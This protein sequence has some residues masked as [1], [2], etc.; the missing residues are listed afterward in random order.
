MAKNE[1]IDNKDKDQG[2]EK[3]VKTLKKS[4]Y[5]KKKKIKKKYIKRYCLCSIYI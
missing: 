2:Q 5:S 1:K 3:L 4:S